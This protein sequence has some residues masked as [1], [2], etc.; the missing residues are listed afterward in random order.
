MTED[1]LCVMQMLG[2]VEEKH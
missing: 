1:C 2:G